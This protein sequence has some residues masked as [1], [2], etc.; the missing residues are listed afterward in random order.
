[1]P[2]SRPSFEFGPF[3]LDCAEHAL[4]RD[5]RRLPLT[6]KVYDVLQLL[7]ENAGYLVEK[8]RLLQ[9]VWPNTFVEEGALNRS[10]SVLRKTLG[11]TEADKYVETVPKRGYRF[12]ATVT[13]IG[14]G[15]AV[16]T[17]IDTGWRPA[18]LLAA[19]ML[20]ALGVFLLRLSGG[21]APAAA[22]V[23]RQVTTS[24]NDS[25]AT[26]SSDGGHLAYVSAAGSERR[27]MVQQV[28][29]GQPVSIFAAPELGYL[30]WSPDGSHLLYW[31]RGA[32]HDGVY[33]IPRMGG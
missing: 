4:S 17:R 32:G 5:G 30:R 31:A 26:L 21:P 33:A 24:G 13:A 19:L 27:L 3:R 1:M 11:E 20:V 2:G 25:A 14:D 16:P 15:S 9:E 29:D 12:V 6:P 22:A 8:E 18:A 23:H 7:V 10:I 28:E